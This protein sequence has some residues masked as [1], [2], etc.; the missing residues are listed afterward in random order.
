MDLAPLAW[1]VVRTL[2]STVIRRVQRSTLVESYRLIRNIAGSDSSNNLTEITHSHQS[3]TPNTLME[4]AEFMA[5]TMKKWSPAYQLNEIIMR[6]VDGCIFG[7]ASYCKFA[8][9]IINSKNTS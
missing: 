2:R 1:C 5:S 6:H 7:H 8:F 3:T 9:Q 4:A